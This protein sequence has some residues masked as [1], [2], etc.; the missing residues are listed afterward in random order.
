MRAARAARYILVASAALLVYL[1]L[2]GIPPFDNW[3]LNSLFLAML[4]LA[5]LF[6]RFE[7]GDYGSREVAVV[8]TLAAVGVA[9]RV[10][11]AAVPGVQPATF[12]AI[13]AGYVFGAEPGFMV[14]ALIAL[15][16]NIFL[17]HGPWTPWQMLAWG[18]AGASG[19]LLA[20]ALRHRVRIVPV[21]VLCTAWGFLFGWIMNF[22]FWLSFIYP[23]TLKSFVATCTT[24][25]WFDFFHAAGN[26]VFALLL[27]W[28]V[29]EMLYRF[30]S[31]FEVEYLPAL[32]GTDMEV[33]L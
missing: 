11:F 14:G 27:T 21:A 31:R 13:L 8:G 7:E 3:S 20:A 4:L 24:S 2:E 25:I 28:P 18:L 6:L 22:W 15:L 23:L 1:G 12:I 26:L 16:S 29:A 32:P 33:Q 17:G 5:V 9:G 10:L 19:G 30:R